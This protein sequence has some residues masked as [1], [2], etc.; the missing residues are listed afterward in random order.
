M[1]KSTASYIM[2]AKHGYKV[3]AFADPVKQMLNVL[4]VPFNHLY[5]S[6]EEKEAPLAVLG[7]K[8]AR[9]AMVTLGTEW[10]RDLIDQNLWVNALERRILGAPDNRIVVEDV[11]FET[12]YEML[13]RN[14]AL[15][16][17]IERPG[18]EANETIVNHRS[19]TWDY[20]QHDIEI[21][22]NDGSLEDLAFTLAH[23]A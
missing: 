10:G 22:S 9:H 6:R 4:G 11:R 21:I 17:A 7:G 16:L 19:E 23:Y 1:G 15:I 2:Q 8:S 5:G 18:V 14:G 20:R 3:M 12:E 13:K